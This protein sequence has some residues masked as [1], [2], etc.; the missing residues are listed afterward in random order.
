MCCAMA[1]APAPGQEL[2]QPVAVGQAR[3][4]ILVGQAA[5]VA[6]V[7]LGRADVLQGD[8]Q[9]V[10]AAH[11]APAYPAQLEWIAIRQFDLFLGKPDCM[12]AR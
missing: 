7:L 11:Q 5:Q 4:A 1:R 12:A 3:Q 10:A 8:G 6:L 9:A 2:L